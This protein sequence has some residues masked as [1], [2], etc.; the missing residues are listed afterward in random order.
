MN[1]TIDELY[2]LSHTKAADYLKQFKYP[3]E[4]LEGIK[5]LIISIGQSLDASEY[6]NPK[7]NVWIAKD[8]KIYQIGRAH[9]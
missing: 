1:C 6:D 8:A 3:W 5:E 2:D 9:V 4:A 7:E